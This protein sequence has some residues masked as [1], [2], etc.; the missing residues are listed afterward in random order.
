MVDDCGDATN[1]LVVFRDDEELTFCMGPKQ[2]GLLK[3]TVDL[4]PERSNPSGVV[5]VHL[6]RYMVK[7]LQIAF[8][9]YVFDPYPFRGGAF[10]S[11]F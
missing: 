5:L 8:V 11:F 9:S 3:K 10:I 6:K 4:I 1:R 2:V 7:Y